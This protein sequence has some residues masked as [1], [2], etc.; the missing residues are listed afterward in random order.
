M[1]ETIFNHVWQGGAAADDAARLQTLTQQLAP[2]RAVD[3][4]EVK[5]QLKANTEEAIAAGAFGSW[6]TGEHHTWKA[7]SNETMT[8]AERAELQHKLLVDNPMRLYWPEE[9]LR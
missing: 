2:Q 4:P 5:N 9:V 7:T 1:C 8:P 3:A 6:R